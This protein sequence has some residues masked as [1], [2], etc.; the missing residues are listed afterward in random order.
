MP[1]R[2]DLLGVGGKIHY[3]G[4]HPKCP[5]SDSCYSGKRLLNEGTLSE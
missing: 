4:K 2:I 5:I 3:G 1:S